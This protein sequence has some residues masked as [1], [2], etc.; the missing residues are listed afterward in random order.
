MSAKRATKS[1]KWIPGTSPQVRAS[2]I[3][4]DSVKL[5]L[6]SVRRLLKRVRCHWQ[7]ESEHVHQ[8]RVATRRAQMAI[9]VFAKFLPT[10]PVRKTLRRLKKFRRAANAARDLDVLLHRYQ[11]QPVSNRLTAAQRNEL[12]HF[13]G[14]KRGEAQVDLDALTDRRGRKTFQRNVRQLLQRKPSTDTDGVSLRELA[15]QELRPLL[16][17]FFQLARLGSSDIEALH[18][19]RIAGKRIRYVM[20]LMAGAYSSDVFETIYRSFCELQ[21]QFGEVNDH[22][23]AVD[24]LGKSWTNCDQKLRRLLDRQVK[25][26]Q[27]LLDR[28]CQQLQQ[29]WTASVWQT[30][31]QQFERLLTSD[32]VG[33]GE[34]ETPGTGPIQSPT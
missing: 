4:G 21:K 17:E 27:Q 29:T 28:R 8:L 33:S 25:A 23:T 32:A 22:A 31:E 10:K 26:E 14:K 18:R 5:R 11:K 6:E 34:T 7:R 9:Q 2:E 12:V 13:L 24:T 19:L 30:L 20:E 1:T 15:D 3:V 16:Q